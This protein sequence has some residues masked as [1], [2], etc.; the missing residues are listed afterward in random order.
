MPIKDQRKQACTHIR[1][2]LMQTQSF[3]VKEVQLL[4]AGVSVHNF[5]LSLH[6]H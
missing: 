4:A 5:L 1:K 2:E 3:Q 6:A